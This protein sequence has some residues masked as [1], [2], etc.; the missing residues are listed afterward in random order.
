MG[1]IYPC[2]A[3]LQR[4]TLPHKLGL[5]SL[6][7]IISVFIYFLF[8]PLLVYWFSPFSLKRRGVNFQLSHIV[9]QCNLCFM[10][11]TAPGW[12]SATRSLPQSPQI[13]SLPSTYRRVL[14][15]GDF[16]NCEILA[17]NFFCIHF[18]H[19]FFVFVSRF[20]HFLFFDSICLDSAVAPLLTFRP[21]QQYAV[22][23]F[24]RQSPAAQHLARH[25]HRITV[26]PHSALCVSV[27][28]EI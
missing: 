5:C 17:Y 4:R 20:L 12:L 14:S 27:Q 1:V 18:L 21:S 9:A 16:G 3:L 15:A 2:L 6:H 26:P 19:C 13:Y 7:C 25:P 24:Q 10:H 8:F 28:L 22:I 11:D 23:V